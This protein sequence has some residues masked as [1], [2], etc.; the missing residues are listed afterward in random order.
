MG[1]PSPPVSNQTCPVCRLA[2]RIP[3]AI[4]EKQHGNPG[5][6]PKKGDCLQMDLRPEVYA[7]TWFSPPP[8]PPPPIGRLVVI[9]SFWQ[10]FWW[11]TPTYIGMWSA[12]RNP[13]ETLLNF[14]WWSIAWGTAE[15]SF[16]IHLELI[17]MLVFWCPG[18][19]RVAC[20]LCPCLHEKSG[21]VLASGLVL[22]SSAFHVAFSNEASY[23]SSKL[24]LV[25]S[26]KYHR[27]TE[28]SLGGS[29]QKPTGPFKKSQVTTDLDPC[30]QSAFKRFLLRVQEVQCSSPRVIQ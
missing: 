9:G 6:Y 10:S 2:P 15:G 3:G 19:I 1:R 14:S 25:R 27:Y 16:F 20:G 8:P 4:V 13:H 24:V 21:L 26:C 22:V 18:G 23:Y 30:Q 11:W 7:V 17:V 29:I 5:K 28:W 12:R